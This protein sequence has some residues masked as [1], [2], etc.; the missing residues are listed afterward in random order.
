MSAVERE[1]NLRI[2]FESCQKNMN[3]RYTSHILRL[4]VLRTPIKNMKWGDGVSISV[5]Q[6]EAATSSLRVATPHGRIHL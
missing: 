1:L 2:Y 5:R 3:I 4:Y 6:Q